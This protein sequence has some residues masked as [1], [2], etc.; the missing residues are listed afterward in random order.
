MAR[1]EP[2]HALHY[3]PA[4]AGPLQDLAA[5]PY[6][7]IDPEQRA[8]LASRSP[9][10][11]VAD[12]P[13]RGPRR[14]RPLRPC[15]RAA[16]AVARRGRRR[17]GRRARVVG[18]RAGL[19]G[20]R[21]PPA[22]AQRLL[23]ARARGGLRPGHDPP[24]RAHAPRPEGGPPAAHPR[25]AGEPVPDLLA[26]LRPGAARLAGARAGDADRRAVRRGHRGRRHAQPPVAHRRPGRDR[27][28]SRPRSPTPSCS[29]PTAT[30]A[31]RPRA[32]TPTR[33]AA[34][35]RTAT[36]SCASSRCRTRA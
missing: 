11:V 32:C 16:R 30:T 2:L 19:H 24:A 34:R 12:R 23:R 17:A 3:D 14:R 26:V 8:E 21:R 29:S 20:S 28:A 15:R 13:P 31:T 33:S 4:V 5:P 7:V 25:D 36:C 18:D 22:H 1:V 35:A 6:D 10:N 9:H 27:R